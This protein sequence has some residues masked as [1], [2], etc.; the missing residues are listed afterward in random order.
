MSRLYAASSFGFEISWFI[1]AIDLVDKNKFLFTKKL[2]EETQYILGIG[3]E[4]VRALEMWLLSAELTV[5]CKEDKQFVT[6]L[7]PLGEIIKKYDPNFYDYNTLAI[8]L[9]HLSK[10]P[11]KQGTEIVY[12]YMNK[13]NHREFIRDDLK[14]ALKSDYSHFKD[15]SIENGLQALLQVFVNSR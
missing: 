10:G 15:A 13:F 9:C 3:S 4:K 2:K 5:K 8:V 6:Y 7:S 14:Q 1:K 12:W 11:K